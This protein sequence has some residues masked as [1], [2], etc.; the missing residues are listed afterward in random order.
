[1]RKYI[2]CTITLLFLLLINSCR[3]AGGFYHNNENHPLAPADTIIIVDNS[4]VDS[5]LG[6]L[7]VYEDSVCS[8]K[9][10]LVYYR[11]S[12]RYEDYING[13]RI[14]KIKYY[15]SICEKNTNNKKYFFGWIR[16]AVSD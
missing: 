12:I 13:R 8:L 5:L 4:M 9:D 6:V 11:D 7:R 10:S 15:I 16:R 1:M 3:C 14:E 2:L